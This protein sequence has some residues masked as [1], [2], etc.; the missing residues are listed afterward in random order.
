MFLKSNGAFFKFLNMC[1]YRFMK[2]YAWNNL[3]YENYKGLLRF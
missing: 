3:D 2:K 1:K